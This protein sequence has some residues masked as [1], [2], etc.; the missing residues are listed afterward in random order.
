MVMF[1]PPILTIVCELFHGMACIPGGDC[2]GGGVRRIVGDGGV[3][4]G[5]GYL[6][7]DGGGGG[8]VRRV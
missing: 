5:D 4:G 6:V 8:V 2:G 3:V 7:G 1:D